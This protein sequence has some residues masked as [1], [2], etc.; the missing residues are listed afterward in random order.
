MEKQLESCTMLAQTNMIKKHTFETVQ[1]KG[2]WSL[3][4]LLPFSEK[5]QVGDFT[6]AADGKTIYFASRL[7]LPGLEKDAEEKIFIF[8][9]KIKMDG[10][11]LN[12]LDLLLIQITVK[13]ARKYFLLLR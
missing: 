10:Q 12:K 2:V 11:S 7:S 3:P 13:T 4:K 8:Q 1:K 6:I 5:Y 9:E